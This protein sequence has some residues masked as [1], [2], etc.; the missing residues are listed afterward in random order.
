M[1][2]TKLSAEKFGLVNNVS[3][4]KFDLVNFGLMNIEYPYAV[5]AFE[6]AYVVFPICPFDVHT[7]A[8]F[9]AYAGTSGIQQS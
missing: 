6:C 7:R 8:I 5:G 9:S 2:V 3:F 4:L 1:S